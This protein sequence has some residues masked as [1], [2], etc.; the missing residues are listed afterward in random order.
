MVAAGRGGW[1]SRIATGDITVCVFVFFACL[2]CVVV[3]SSCF[4]LIEMHVFAIF[5]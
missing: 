5:T 2:M 4:V 3:V 1:R